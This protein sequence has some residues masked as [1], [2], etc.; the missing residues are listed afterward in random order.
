[1]K[2]VSVKE[3][4][5]QVIL[6]MVIPILGET[7]FSK[8]FYIGIRNIGGGSVDVCSFGPTPVVSM[9]E[10]ISTYLFN[11]ET[12]RVGSSD[13]FISGTPHFI[14]GIQVGELITACYTPACEPYSSALAAVYGM[15]HHCS[16]GR[17][18]HSLLSAGTLLSFAKNWQ[19]KNLP[20]NK[21]LLPLLESILEK[22]LVH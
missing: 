19:E 5:A 10:D 7:I 3:R 13:K 4:V 8:F 18:D 17:V 11:I 14:A 12:E 6:E 22:E 16:E 21:I 1:M 2:S 15:L 20:D 9:K